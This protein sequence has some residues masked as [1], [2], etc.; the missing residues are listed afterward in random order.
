[1]TATP[2]PLPDRTKFVDPPIVELVVSLFHLPITELKAQHI[3]LY[4]DQ[5]RDR[6]PI[7]EQQ[8]P[9]VNPTDPQP[10][11]EAT[12]ELFPLPR[13]W[14]RS[15]D[16][17]TLIQIQRNAF[18]LNWRRT[19]GA[20]D[21]PHYESVVNDFWQQ[22]Q[23]YASFVKNAVG[24]EIEA[25]QRCE[26]NYINII[27]TN[28][29][30]PDIAHVAGALPSLSGLQT[31]ATTDRQLMG[32]NSTISH[33]LAP[34]LAADLIIRLGRLSESG[35]QALVL[36]LKAHGAPKNLAVESARQWYDEAHDVTYRLF[37]DVTAKELQEK[38]WKRR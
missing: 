33:R 31:I 1:M 26:L 16:H 18:M 5:I 19:P 23:T 13:F 15:D 2:S 36:E 37:L 20:H 35:D 9:V 12:G 14:F 17:P 7:C 3:G 10:F 25:V 6:F 24:S 22:F 30:F 11:M 28:P 27:P 34:H 4:W 29:F 8:S 38:I 32:M 21:Y